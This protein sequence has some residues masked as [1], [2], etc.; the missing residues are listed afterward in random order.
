MEWSGAAVLK[1]GP[2]GAEYV[3]TVTTSLAPASS[4]AEA[5]KADDGRRRGR[6]RVPPALAKSIF[7]KNVRR[8]RTPSAV[9]AALHL[10]QEDVQQLLRRLAVVMLEDAV[11][12][13]A[14]PAVGE[15]M[16]RPRREGGGLTEPESLAHGRGGERLRSRPLPRRAAP[17]S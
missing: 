13:P 11:L 8:R 17:R 15:Y 4:A 2:L 16:R 1:D 14:L 12:H 10:L 7:Q 6:P 9:R 3:L 5:L